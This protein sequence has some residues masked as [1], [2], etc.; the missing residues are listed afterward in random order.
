MSGKGDLKECLL[1][2]DNLDG[3]YC[4]K[5][6]EVKLLCMESK[7]LD[8]VD[9]IK[10][11]STPTLV[12]LFFFPLGVVLAAGDVI[13]M[14]GLVAFNDDDDCGSGNG[15]DDEEANCFDEE[16]FII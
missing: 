14:D 7:V 6:D 10:A 13:K 3:G 5:L 12:F 1:Y 16:V 8:E 15:G 9:F 4:N 2:G 11:F